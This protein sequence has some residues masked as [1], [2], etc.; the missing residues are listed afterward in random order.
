M[1]ERQLNILNL[2]ALK[3]FTSPQVN[4]TG[5]NSLQ[6]TLFTNLSWNM[7]WGIVPEDYCFHRRRAFVGFQKNVRRH[8]EKN[9]F[10]HWT[11]D[12]G[13]TTRLSMFYFGPNEKCWW[14]RD[15]LDQWD[16]SLWK[17]LSTNDFFVSF[18]GLIMEHILSSKK[19]DLRENAQRDVNSWAKSIRSFLCFSFKPAWYHPFCKN[20]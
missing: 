5:S 10:V 17:V 16:K 19:S 20:E 4:G 3:C 13:P 14:M 6:L 2:E 7:A 12:G 8:R 1:G 11:F 15:F 18:A 9:R